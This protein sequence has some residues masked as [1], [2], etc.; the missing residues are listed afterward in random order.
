MHARVL[1]IDLALYFKLLLCACVIVMLM[2]HIDSSFCI[3][4]HH[5]CRQ[6]NNSLGGV[7]LKPVK[8]RFFLSFLCLNWI[9]SLS[10]FFFNQGIHFVF[11]IT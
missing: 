1:W 4:S 5:P 7:P 9:Y 6:L 2:H 3:M 10:F 8:Y 11:G